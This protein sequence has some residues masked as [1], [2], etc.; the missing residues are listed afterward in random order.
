MFF[1]WC[2]I[3]KHFVGWGNFFCFCSAQ[4]DGVDHRYW[5]G[6]KNWKNVTIDIVEQMTSTTPHF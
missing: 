3:W 2:E 1:M 4:N 6:V 5:F